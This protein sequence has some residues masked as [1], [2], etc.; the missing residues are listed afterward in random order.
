MTG[1]TE[2]KFIEI[3]NNNFDL[4]PYYNNG[5]IAKFDPKTGHPVPE[6]KREEIKHLVDMM[7]IA[8]STNIGKE[9]FGQLNP[10][11][12]VT[13]L[14]D[15]SRKSKCYGYS[16]NNHEIAITD[17]SCRPRGNAVTF[18]HELTHE[19][20]RQQ[21]GNSRLLAT[22]QDRFMANKLMEA[23]ARLN[24]AKACLELNAQVLSE[25]ERMSFYDS[26]SLQDLKDANVYSSML[27]N[28]VPEEIINSAML[29]SFYKDPNWNEDYNKQALMSANYEMSLNKYRAEQSADTKEFQKT[30]MKRMK[31]RPEDAEYF[32]NPENM[33]S[34]P[35]DQIKTKKEA[36]I[37]MDSGCKLN[38]VTENGQV[39]QRVLYDK[40]DRIMSEER[41]LSEKN[42]CEKVYDSNGNMKRFINTFTYGDEQLK[43]IE[44]NNNVICQVFI[45]NNEIK[46]VYDAENK[47]IMNEEDINKERSLVHNTFDKI[48]AGENV[49]DKTLIDTA[50]I[51]VTDEYG[52][53]SGYQEVKS[54]ISACVLQK[55]STSE[56]SFENSAQVEDFQKVYALMTENNLKPI[57]ESTDKQIIENLSKAKLVQQETPSQ[58]AQEF[59]NNVPEMPQPVNEQDKQSLQSGEILN[60]YSNDGNSA[61][62]TPQATIIKE[63]KEFKPSEEVILDA[64]LREGKLTREQEDKILEMA[65]FIEQKRLKEKELGLETQNN[66][67]EQ[68]IDKIAASKDFSEDQ[69]SVALDAAIKADNI[70]RLRGLTP[71]KTQ[72]T[73]TKE[74]KVNNIAMSNIMENKSN[75][76]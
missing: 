75:T 48:A 8:A 41:V 40:N 35:K 23:E 30:Y 2:E 58:V 32:F 17:T 69:K 74:Q 14:V 7:R 66:Y 6:E 22:E 4:G 71:S 54:R 65:T 57:D 46:G 59:V 76:L 47:L 62:Q 49:D 39:V 36:T 68:F 73:Q 3:L 44:E 37:N 29:N 20:Q 21:G 67:A 61:V 31:L 24:T 26:L 27:R 25:E 45:K 1:L 50:K 55:L 52:I 56:K 63:E 11:V 5:S 53:Y 28:N 19:I 15:S 60:T 16:T 12:K 13:L 10:D 9:L 70:M 43:T 64:L 33:T 18:L 72:P 34:Y 42:T 38:I 51:V